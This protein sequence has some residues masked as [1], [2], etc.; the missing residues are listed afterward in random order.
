M[1][2]LLLLTLCITSALTYANDC[3][4]KVGIGASVSHHNY[5]NP[6]Q[7]YNTLSAHGFVE[8]KDANNPFNLGL[9]ARIG[10]YGND[11]SNYPNFNTKI[12][13]SYSF[14]LRVVIPVDDDRKLNIGP[15]IGYTSDYAAETTSSDFAE[16]QAYYLDLISKYSIDDF[17]IES[18][19]GYAF[20]GE[21]EFYD[22]AQN[23]TTSY[24]SA[25]GLRISTGAGYR[26]CWQ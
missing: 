12:P 15:S 26:I 7:F 23:N 11:Q 2:K 18:S 24:S 14:G 8:I 13:K 20:N 5:S 17:W 4:Y 3:N 25:T 10:L 6:G 19:L 21:T 22:S 9:E 1:K 16:A